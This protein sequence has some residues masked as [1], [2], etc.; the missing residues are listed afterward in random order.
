MA[1]AGVAADGEVLTVMG[2]KHGLEK[3]S[4]RMASEIGGN[5]PYPNFSV[6]PGGIRMGPCRRSP[7]NPVG[8][9][10]SKALL[11]DI[12]YGIPLG[13]VHGEKE[14]GVRLRTT[15]AGAGGFPVAFQS[16]IELPLVLS[17]ISQIIVRFGVIRRRFN[18]LTVL[19]G[20]L[21]EPVE[22]P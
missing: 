3:V 1:S 8:P 9:V 21:L 7:G 11:Q 13:I 19:N 18:G 12:P 10:P 6:L 17:D 20:G 22:V 15:P 14:I 4:H 16:I 2:R 5:I